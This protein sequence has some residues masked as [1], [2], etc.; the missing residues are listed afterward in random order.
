MPYTYYY[1]SN[2][3]I[4]ITDNTKKIANTC[5]LDNGLLWE[6]QSIIFF[7]DL[8]K[9]DTKVNIIDIGANVG[10]YSLYA[11]YLPNAHFYS[12]EPF[13][14][15][16]NLLNENILLNDIN[17]ITTY[18]LALGDKQCKTI[19]N[20]CISHNGLHTM[21]NN[22]LRFND[23]K[24]VEID[25]NTLDNLFFNN[26]IKVDYIKI[27]TEGYEF[28]ILKGG[29]KTIKTYKPIIQLEYNI[30]NMKQCNITP[31]QLINYINNELQY[32]IYNLSDEEL[33]IIPK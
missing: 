31:Q 20:T 33:I 27:D 2:Q 15:T 22:P 21:G 4:Q 19:L 3:P 25:V 23:I 17:N 8:I 13:N 6:Y 9:K 10:L 11:K 12:F 18:N 30:I 28:Y 24:P 29:E 32:K 14:I 7:F 16:Y 5:F 26:N 1:N